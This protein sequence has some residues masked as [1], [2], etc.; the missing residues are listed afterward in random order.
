MEH[1][2]RMSKP[3]LIFTSNSTFQLIS[4]IREKFKFIQSHINLTKHSECVS[5]EELLDF[6]DYN[7]D[8]FELAQFDPVEQVA[9]I[10]NSSGT[11][12]LPKGVLITH[13]NL[14]CMFGYFGNPRFIP[15]GLDDV[16][17]SVCPFYHLYGVIIS[18]IT[19]VTGMV[20][21]V[22]SKYKNETY[23]ELIET[24]HVTMLFLVP[25]MAMI[26]AK[27]PLVDNYKLDSLK[28][29]F[30]GAAP[31]GIEVQT[32]LSSR[33]NV[34]IQQLY[35]MTELTGLVTIMPTDVKEFK[36]TGCVGILTPGTLAMVRDLETDL[37]LG[38]YQ[39]GELCFKGRF[40]MKGYINN[41][42]A[43]QA[44]I[45]KDS[46]LRTGDL[47]Y[48]DQDGYFYVVDRLKELI[49]YKGF[50]VPPAELE[51]VINSNESVA[52]SAVIG[53]P[54]DFAGELAVA[55]VV[56]KPYSDI[57]E[58]DIIEYVAK[59]LSREKHIYGGVI[60]LDEIPKTPS[61]KILRKELRKV[62]I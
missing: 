30:C 7:I 45:D 16:T 38:P 25:P 59:H 54:D 47:G 13:D 6:D 14:R 28:W 10:L 22:M 41:P 9:I 29:I 32:M 5:L 1:V 60:F 49:K 57:S 50:Q 27:S 56:K 42:G 40:I 20:S 43:S 21:V 62:I 19:M 37:P 8:D 39:P 3:R 46:Y 36:K 24:Y 58:Q 31:L 53:K 33:L 55:F 17:L 52:D 11:T 15:S 12:G 4:L 18:G 34:T 23:L 48:Y 35:G 2:L 51:D 44:A 26:L 61:G